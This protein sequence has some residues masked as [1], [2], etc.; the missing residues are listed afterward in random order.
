MKG[1][2]QQ[3]ITLRNAS[4]L[5]DQRHKDTISKDDCGEWNLQ[6]GRRAALYHWSETLLLSLIFNSPSIKAIK[7]ASSKST[8]Q[9]LTVE[10][11]C[12]LTDMVNDDEDNFG[13]NAAAV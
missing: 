7:S 9:S 10:A 2:I 5:S 3:N 6:S 12:S 1:L 8:Q 11:M 4:Y 13:G